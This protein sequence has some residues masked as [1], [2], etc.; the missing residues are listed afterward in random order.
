MLTV[1]DIFNLDL[2]SDISS[3]CKLGNRAKSQLIDLFKENLDF[4]INADVSTEAEEAYLK[5]KWV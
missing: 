4:R 2:A 1:V 5:I 3:L